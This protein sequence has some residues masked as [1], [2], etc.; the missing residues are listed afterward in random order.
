MGLN[1]RVLLGAVVALLAVALPGQAVAEPEVDL[2]AIDRYVADFADNAGYPGVAFAITKDDQVVHVSGVGHDSSGAAVT[3]TTPMPVASVSKSFTALAV[4]RLVEQGKVALDAPVRR[5]V[6]DFRIADPRGAEITVRQL[7]NQTSGITDGTLAEKS[8]PQPDSLAG[9]VT[10][11]QEATLAVDPGTKHYYTNTNYHLAGRLVEVVTGEPFADHLRRTVFE[12]AGMRATTVLEV[13]PGNVQKGHIFAYGI[14]VPAVE[15]ARF[16]TGTDG[17]ISTA[18]DLAQWLIVQSNGGAAADGTRLVSPESVTAMHTSSDPRWTYGMGW[19]TADGR[20]RHGGIWFTYSA[21]A[22]LLPSGY[23]IAVLTNSGVALGNEGTR[24]VE[25]GIATLLEGGTP[26]IGAPTRLLTDLVLAALTL[27]SLVLGVL[28][29]R[30]SD[31]WV[32]RFGTRPIG[33]LA[34][35]LV[36]RV[37]P[38]VILA[39]APYLLSFLVGGGR[40]ITYVQLGYYSVA[41]VTWLLVSSALNLAV[42]T[43]RVVGLV[44][45]RRAPASMQVPAL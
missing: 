21:G 4:M 20:V 18:E 40:D 16:L 36:P 1:K 33:Y 38:A 34:L 27:L 12:P 6:R 26:A 25:S 43:I 7:L 19:D 41:L 32:R 31:R 42:A 29:L 23:G 44:R 45:L 30:R 3:A 17:I 37:F 11:A 8:L 24:D 2:A 9:A 39:S 5:Y 15:P 28:A 22:L 14:S 10:R 35:R 13:A